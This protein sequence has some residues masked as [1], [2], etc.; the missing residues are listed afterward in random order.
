VAIPD[1]QTVMRPILD[2]HVRDG[3]TVTDRTAMRDAIA[4]QF[5]L[6][7]D[8]RN[9]VL[10]SGRQRRFDNRVG[11]ALTHLSK[12]GL[13]DRPQ[14]GVTTITDRGRKVLEDN[15]ETVDMRVLQEFEEY[16]EFHRGSNDSEDSDESPAVTR[17]AGEST[18]DTPEE[19]LEAAFT[20]L[21]DALASSLRDKLAATS[22]EFFEQVVVDVL[23]AM[24]YG[25]SRREAGQRLGR[26]GDEGIDGVIRE[27][28]LGL[29]A[30]Y[31]QAKR[32]DP[33]RA[34]GRRGSGVRR[35]SVRR[36]GVE[37]RVHHHVPVHVGRAHLC[38]LG[39][40]SRC[41]SGRPPT[42]ASDDRARRRCDAPAALR[43]QAHR[44]GLLPRGRPVKARLSRE[45]AP[46][47]RQ[48]GCRDDRSREVA[49]RVVAVRGR[50]PRR[51][52]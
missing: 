21:T 28:A 44:R 11:W 33:S 17:M 43:P 41:A 48:G 22:P 26:S 36:S 18:G 45:R 8:E 13:L 15:P 1:F 4:D 37:G 52:R 12:G 47:S 19:T 31:L 10:P 40:P 16:R 23:V 32:W 50:R 5:G 39:H 7:D 25:G 24:G 51:R 29:D 2:Y 34:V 14:R 3:G 46:S 9:E 20:V 35:R 38:R 27:D 30:I 6:T 49:P 42:R